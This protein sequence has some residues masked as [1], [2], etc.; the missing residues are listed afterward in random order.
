MQGALFRL[1]WTEKSARKM[2]FEVKIIK[3]LVFFYENFDKVNKISTFAR[4]E[5][6]Y[7]F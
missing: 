2:F 5:K 6:G 7:K 3:K 4:R 1:P